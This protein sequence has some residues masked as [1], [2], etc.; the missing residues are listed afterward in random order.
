MQQNLVCHFVCHLSVFPFLNVFGGP[1]NQLVPINF[2][3]SILYIPFTLSFQ[4]LTIFYFQISILLWIKTHYLWVDKIFNI[5]RPQSFIRNIL[6]L[7]KWVI[8]IRK[9]ARFRSLRENQILLK[10]KN[11]WNEETPKEDSRGWKLW[12]WGLEWPV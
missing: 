7:L 1:F 10:K 2:H 3:K 12:P 5:S 11:K 9:F 4:S 6:C 8:R